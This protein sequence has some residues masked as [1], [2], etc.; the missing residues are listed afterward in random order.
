MIGNRCGRRFALVL[1]LIAPWLA[2]A[3]N[4]SERPDQAA[5]LLGAET[6]AFAELSRPGELI[7]RLTSDDLQGFLRTIPGYGRALESPR[8]R[9]LSQVATFLAEQL[10]TTWEEGLRTLTGNGVV[11][12]LEQADPPRLVI[13]ATPEDPAF[14][15]KAH[16][17]LVDLARQDASAKGKADPVK[18]NE[19]RG[20]KV[21]SVS[22]QEAHAI[23]DGRLV[24]ASGGEALKAVI[25][26]SMD[27]GAALTTTD[28][29]AARRPKDEP[30]AWGYARLD[31]L[32]EMG[33]TPFGG[34][35]KPDAGAVLLLG[36]WLDRLRNAPWAAATIDWSADRLDGRLTIPAPEGSGA[37]PMALFFPPEGQ[38]APR[39]I[40]VDGQLATI[41]LWRDQAALWE[42]R[43]DLLPPEALQGLAQLD[44]FAGQFFG[45]R[46]FGDSVLKPLGNHWQLV[47]ATQDYGG[48]DPAPELKLPGFALIV[49]LDADRPEF[50]QRLR[51]AF[52]S[53]LGLVNLGAA[54]SGSGAPPLE[55][56]SETYE[57]ITI[58]KA[59]FMTM[60]DGPETT[61][62]PVH[63]RHNY[64]PSIAEAEG[65][66][67]VS[68]SVGLTKQIIDALKA[69][70]TIEPTDATLLMAADGAGLAALVD[71]NRERLVLQNMLDDGHDRATAERNIESLAALLR[72]LGRGELR[73]ADGEDASTLTIRFDLGSASK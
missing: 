15:E 28:Q 46:D 53:I 71:L 31:R 57:G 2:T 23:L 50:A 38:G 61:T 18:E 48:M 30:L 35:E 49:E 43:E 68:S 45:G 29:Y 19:H 41:N 20:V 70:P 24:I 12:G 4:A 7:D 27:G 67:I 1:T 16:A 63:Y 10:D 56:G 58:S 44:S 25:D 14:L 3:A 47:A 21:Y 33:V 51:V 42:V 11:V 69:D 36:G 62:E 72:Y 32:R 60:A 55:L 40:R 5:G 37:G 17:L 66:F 52:Q 39:P 34:D 65:R 6:V 73:I 64:S 54:Q 59:T 22:D 13:V 8:F 26:R 9:E